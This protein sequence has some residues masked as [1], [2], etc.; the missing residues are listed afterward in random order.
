[1]IHLMPCMPK[2]WPVLRS[3]LAKVPTAPLVH[4]ANMLMPAKIV[5]LHL[6][7]DLPSSNCSFHISACAQ[8]HCFCVHV[9]EFDFQSA[10]CGCKRRCHLVHTSKQHVYAYRV[11]QSRLSPSIFCPAP[12]VARVVA[13]VM[14][15]SRFPPRRLP[16]SIQPLCK[17]CTCPLPLSHL[18]LKTANTG[19]T[20]FR[21]CDVSFHLSWKAFEL[22]MW[23]I[24]I[25]FAGIL[26]SC[27]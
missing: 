21:C 27:H 23:T 5:L 14:A 11:I 19:R 7:D 12:A 9:L 8:K 20:I 4:H 26:H 2:P 3:H 1:M 22:L 18:L 13:T 17:A 15:T 24:T 10:A 16:C 6:Q 25:T